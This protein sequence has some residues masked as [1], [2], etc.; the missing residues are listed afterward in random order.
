MPECKDCTEHSG[1][2]V[3]LDTLEKNVTKLWDKINAM[4]TL[5]ITTLVSSLLSLSVLF[6]RTFMK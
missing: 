3:R 4:H 1:I 6:V 2:E 5:L